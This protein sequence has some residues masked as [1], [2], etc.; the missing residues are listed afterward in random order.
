MHTVMWTF[1]VPEGT[2]KDSLRQTIKATAHTYQG[3][4]GLIRKYY[5]IHADGKTLV[6]IY[7]WESRAAADRMYTAEWVAMVTR[8]WGVPPLRE[9]WETPMVVESA[10]KR[11][12]EAA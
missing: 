9:E 4:P 12:V 10:E 3:I 5:G 7:L 2:S 11:L 6:G 1:Q 8:R